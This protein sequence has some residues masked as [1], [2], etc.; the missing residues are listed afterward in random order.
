[1]LYNDRTVDEAVNKRSSDITV[2]HTIRLGERVVAAT[3]AVIARL[4]VGQQWVAVTPCPPLL[5]TA[6]IGGTSSSLPRV[7]AKISSATDNGHSSLAAGNG[8]HAP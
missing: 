2:N 8:L 1:V 6:G 7:P 4:A 3:K 5:R